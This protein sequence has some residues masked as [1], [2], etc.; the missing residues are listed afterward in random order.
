MVQK[1]IGQKGKDKIVGKEEVEEEEEEKMEGV[2][3]NGGEGS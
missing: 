1:K 3:R 2:E